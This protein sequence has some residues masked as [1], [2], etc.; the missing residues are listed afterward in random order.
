MAFRGSWPSRAVPAVVDG[1]LR[2]A[3][4]AFV[5]GMNLSALVGAVVAAVAAVGVYRLLPHR[6]RP[7]EV[8]VDALVPDAVA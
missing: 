1:L 8:P 5:D 6:R 3:E 4:Q 2:A 7:A